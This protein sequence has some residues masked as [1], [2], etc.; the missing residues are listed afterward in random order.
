MSNK[1]SCPCPTGVVAV[2][3][4]GTSPFCQNNR[5]FITSRFLMVCVMGLFFIGVSAALQMAVRAQSPASED[6][7]LLSPTAS[8]G[9]ALAKVC[10]QNRKQCPPGFDDGLFCNGVETCTPDTLECFFTVSYN[11]TFGDTT[12][13]N[14]AFDIVDPFGGATRVPA[15]GNLQI[16]SISGNTTCTVGGAL[17]C[18]IGP[19]I[20]GGTSG[21]VTFI[22]N[23]YVIQP[24]DPNPLENQAFTKVQDKCDAVG[25]TGCT[26][27][28]QT[29]S[30]GATTSLINGTVAGTPPCGSDGNACTA[31]S[32]D[33]T[34]DVCLHVPKSCDDSDACT[35]DTCDP[36]TG[37]CS[38]TPKSC[39]DSDACTADSCDPA[40]GVCANVPKSCDD[41]DSCT[42]DTCDP[43]T[44]DCHNV[45][46]GSCNVGQG[47]TPGFWKANADKKGANAWPVSPNTLLSSVFTI[48]ACLS[49]CP[50]NYN[51]ITLRQAL[52]L[53]GGKT[54]CQ[55][56]EILLRAATSAY[57]NSLSTCVQYPIS[58][59]T[60][61][62][63]VNAALASCDS[64]D[65]ITEATR[66]DGFNNLSCP[67]NQ[68]G[69][70]S[71]P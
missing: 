19:A 18:T 16:D 22:Q 11:D 4:T 60:L 65:I 70:C 6:G 29:G 66:L 55:K 46:N 7:L 48:P 64:G 10:T 61:V 25:T 53:Q 43:A 23:T 62:T 49:G 1:I 32:C 21:S 44:G 33:E 37:V 39:D 69:Q 26:T 50:E 42:D 40:T 47:C 9:V 3:S 2:T 71:N 41:N 38:N 45:L 52:S 8:H 28:T 17:P 31:D 5:R 27:T 56:A 67:L 36:A 20:G 13:I 58:T 30:F 68:Q 24:T 12:Q 54:L 35:T 34:N 14:E 59:G 15:A 63:E 57:L 51:T